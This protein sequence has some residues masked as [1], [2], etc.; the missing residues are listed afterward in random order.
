MFT[1]TIRN[2]FFNFQA[3]EMGK[4][5]VACPAPEETLH[6]E[7]FESSKL[8]FMWALQPQPVT[9]APRGEGRAYQ[10]KVPSIEHP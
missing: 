6:Q 3:G 9:S 7:P 2:H 1:F 5:F 10:D 8:P 4:R